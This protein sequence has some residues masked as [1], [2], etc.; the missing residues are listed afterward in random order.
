VYIGAPHAFNEI[1][2]FNYIKKRLYHGVKGLNDNEKRMEIRGLLREWKA[3]IMC[4]DE[5]KMKVI[6]RDVV[7]GL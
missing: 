4:L 7:L 6:T 3:D 2:I 5:T 1:G